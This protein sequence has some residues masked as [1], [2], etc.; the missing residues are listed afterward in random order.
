MAL[1]WKCFRY[2][3]IS[4]LAGFFLGRLLPKRWF[5]TDRFPFRPYA[6]EKN[7]RFYHIFGIRFWYKRVPDMSK[8]VPI[9]MPAKN[10]SGDYKERLYLLLQETCIAEFVHLVLCLTGFYCLVIWPG[11][12]GGICTFLYIVFFHFP[13][14]MIQRYNRP[15]L[16]KLW[17][18]TIK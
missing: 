12:G 16:M 15:R 10:L 17:K 6:F 8:I 3:V 11:L 7:G 1:F 5:R 13:Y 2:C 4:S 14:I 9:L 18:K